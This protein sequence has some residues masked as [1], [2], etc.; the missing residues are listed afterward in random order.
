[1]S[2]KDPSKPLSSEDLVRLLLD[3]CDLKIRE[4]VIYERELT[5][6]KIKLLINDY[7]KRFDTMT[8]DFSRNDTVQHEIIADLNLKMKSF[9]VY[10]EQLIFN[11]KTGKLAF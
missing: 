11:L 1:M 10:H 6:D 2:H 3:S 9:A 8:D 7:N 4:S 5:N